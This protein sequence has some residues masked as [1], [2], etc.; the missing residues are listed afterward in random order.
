MR[1]CGPILHSAHNV[2]ALPMPSK[3]RP[4]RMDNKKLQRQVKIIKQIQ[5]MTDEQLTV[6]MKEF[7][8]GLDSWNFNMNN[9]A[10]FMQLL[11]QM[12]PR[13]AERFMEEMAKKDD[14]NE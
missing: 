4:K 6:F 7:L 11:L 13:L 8:K 10:M 1:C 2:M 5:E 12:D 9:L 3:S 14:K